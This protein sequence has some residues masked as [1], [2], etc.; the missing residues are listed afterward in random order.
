MKIILPKISPTS[1]KDWF[2]ITEKNTQFYK[3]LNDNVD[4]LR[5]S[6]KKDVSS[7]SLISDENEIEEYSF[8]KKV[9]MEKKNFAV[10]N[11]KNKNSKLFLQIYKTDANKE[12][13]VK[14]IKRQYRNIPLEDYQNR[15]VN[16]FYY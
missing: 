10:L 1:N 2:Y 13:L 9:L 5:E 3:Y 8:L 6:V 15:L 12:T 16:I 7:G 4:S 14:T 11:K